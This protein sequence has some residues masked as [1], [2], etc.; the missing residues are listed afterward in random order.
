MHQSAASHDHS[1]PRL[2]RL[3][4]ERFFLVRLYRAAKWVTL[5]V[6]V[7][8]ATA[9]LAG[10]YLQPPTTGWAWLDAERTLSVEV[11]VDWAGVDGEIRRVF[12]EARDRAHA[13]ARARLDAWHAELMGRVEGDFLPWYFGFWN[14]E[15]RD[16]K[17][18]GYL[19]ADWAGFTDA[20]TAMMA[21]FRDA[22]AARV[23]PPA[24]TQ[25]RMEAIARAALTAYLSHARE[26]LP[27]IPAEYGVPR[28]DWQQHLAHIGLQLQQ[29]STQDE[30]VPT[31]LK[32]LVAV[33]AAGTAAAVLRGGSALSRVGAAAGRLVPRAGATAGEGALV[34]GSLRAR[35]ARTGGRQ[36]AKSGGRVGGR[37][38]GIAALVGF[39]AWDA[40]DYARTE[41]ELRPKLRARLGAYLRMV[42][43]RMLADPANGVLAPVR[44]VEGRVHEQLAG[45]A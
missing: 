36:A 31:S 19:A 6:L 2:N 14:Q 7:L 45:T 28:D 5:L 9:L 40:Y 20:E 24:E 8:L 32:G 37:V 17:A 12:S 22:F 25:L 21:D 11:P 23:M 30:Q 34:A 43:E 29:A 3:R 16:L 10:R 27:D 38:L 18:A 44:E 42:T 15:W 13:T 33:G 41:A 35:V 39:L 4:P 26:R 1:P